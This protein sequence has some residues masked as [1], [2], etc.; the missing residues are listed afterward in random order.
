LLAA[1]TACFSSLAELC[2]SSGPDP[3]GSRFER[4]LRST[5]H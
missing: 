5:E 2:S 3:H 1:W 4:P